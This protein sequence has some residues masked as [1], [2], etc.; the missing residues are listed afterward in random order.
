MNFLSFDQ[1]RVG[2]ESRDDDD[3][4]GHLL[5]VVRFL[6]FVVVCVVVCRL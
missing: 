1:Q 2:R 4:E 6:T 5:P 3:A